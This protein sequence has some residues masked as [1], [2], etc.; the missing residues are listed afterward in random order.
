MI[1]KKGEKK[2]EVLEKFIFGKKQ[3]KCEDGYYID[4]DFIV[5]VDGV[6][7]KGKKLWDGKTSGEYAKDIIINLFEN[8]E[9]D[10][11]AEDLILKLNSALYE[12]YSEILTSEEVNEFLRA[13][14]IIY[15]KF[16]NEIWSFGDLQCMINNE[17]FDH[18]KLI[19][20][21]NSKMR[22]F[23]LEFYLNN[24]YTID[25][26]KKEDLGRNLIMPFLKMQQYF[27]NKDGEFGYAVLNGQSINVKNIVK[28]KVKKGD[29]VVLA[30][31]GY[32]KLFDNLS[33]SE[34]FLKEV[35]VSDPLCYKDNKSTKGLVEGNFSFDDRCYIKFIV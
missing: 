12:A 25:D 17:V 6:T 14:I 8:I 23:A 29:I 35:L 18:A 10:I 9:K 22:S 13:G 1:T 4:D 2:M 11:S 20:E 31:D 5:V 30:S 16:Y 21:L 34:E 27:E 26:I 32:P 19:D 24:G 15:S 7:S 33:T 3:D 28:Y